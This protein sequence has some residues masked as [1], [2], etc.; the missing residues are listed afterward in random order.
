MNKWF[1]VV[2]ITKADGSG[3]HFVCSENYRE[4]FEEAKEI[5]YSVYI[6]IIF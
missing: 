1:H 3:L 4:T 5:H 2:A 6:N